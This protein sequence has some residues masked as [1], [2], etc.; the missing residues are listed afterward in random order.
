MKN[1]DIDPTVKRELDSLGAILV[2]QGRHYIFNIRGFGNIVISRSPSDKR[3]TKANLSILKRARKMLK[4]K[5][6]E[7]Q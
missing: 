3:A 5:M 6:N 1:R 7:E 4:V 2:R